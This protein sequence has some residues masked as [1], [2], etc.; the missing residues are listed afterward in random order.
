MQVSPRIRRLE[1]EK[2]PKRVWFPK[3]NWTA[4]WILF[5]ILFGWAVALKQEPQDAAIGPPLTQSP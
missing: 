4:V 3:T 1:V 5:A 2:K